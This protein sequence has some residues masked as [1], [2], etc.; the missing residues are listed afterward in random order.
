M[1]LRVA[2]MKNSDDSFD[3]IRFSVGWWGSAVDSEVARRWAVLRMRMVGRTVEA[4]ETVEV[5]AMRGRKKKRTR[6]TLVHVRAAQKISRNY[7]TS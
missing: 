5:E 6:N 1:F 2:V 7:Y 4:K 3:S